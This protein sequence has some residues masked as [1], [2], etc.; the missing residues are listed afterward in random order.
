MFTNK[1]NNF[2][3]LRI[4]RNNFKHHSRLSLKKQ[5]FQ[6]CYSIPSTYFFLSLN[7]DSDNSKKYLPT[8]DNG[9]FPKAFEEFEEFPNYDSSVFPIPHVSCH[10]YSHQFFNTSVKTITRAKKNVLTTFL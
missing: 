5:K 7:Y 9:I 10:S 3:F 2:V 8:K 1:Y 4:T 6:I